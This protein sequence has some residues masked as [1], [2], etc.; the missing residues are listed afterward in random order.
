MFERKYMSS[1]LHLCAASDVVEG[2]PISVEID[3]MPPLAVYRMDDEIFVTDRT[4]THGDADLTEGFQE[5][6]EIECPFHGV[7]ESG[8]FDFLLDGLDLWRIGKGFFLPAYPI[9]ARARFAIGDAGAAGPET[10]GDRC[11]YFLGVCQPDAANQMRVSY[12]CF[13]PL[14]V[15]YRSI[16]LSGI[17]IRQ[18]ET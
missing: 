2:V 12:H 9:A 10:I 11:E 7:F 8:N 5:G 16:C 18:R 1:N 14:S 6:S 3:G 4:C 17:V 15:G 13:L